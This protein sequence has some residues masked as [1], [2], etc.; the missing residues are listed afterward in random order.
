LR[1]HLLV[2]FQKQSKSYG[3]EHPS[4]VFVSLEGKRRKIRVFSVADERGEK[5]RRKVSEKK[6]KKYGPRFVCVRW[7]VE[8]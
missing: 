4:L 1:K 6:G 8:N 5:I 2:F 3:K 7:K